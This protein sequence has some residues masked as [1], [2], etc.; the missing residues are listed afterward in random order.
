M[1]FI[2]SGDMHLERLPQD[3]LM[4][5]PLAGK[6][7]RLIRDKVALTGLHP[8]G[9][10]EICGRMPRVYPDSRHDLLRVRSPDEKAAVIPEYEGVQPPVEIQGRLFWFENRTD[11]TN[12]TTT[13]WLL[14]SKTDGSDRRLEWE[15]QDEAGHS[16]QFTSLFVTENRLYG[17]LFKRN[18][19][20]I[21]SRESAEEPTYRDDYYL[22][23]IT[24]EDPS[25]TNPVHPLPLGV[26]P[27]KPHVAGG[28]YYFLYM[29][30]KRSPLDFLSEQVQGRFNIWLCR[31]R[32]P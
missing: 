2:N 30:T 24:P 12:Q 27:L 32:L 20:R 21:T 18:R 5:T 26:G 22:T 4:F 29:E 17:V 9:T 19:A 10:R 1:Q 6:P 7:A 31:V 16:M 14:S 13:G 15:S 3:T 23:R 11:K 28:Y 8:C 25:H